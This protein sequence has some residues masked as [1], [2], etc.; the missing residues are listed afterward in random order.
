MNNNK[1]LSNIIDAL[2]HHEDQSS[3][4]VLE[5]VGTNCPDD[6]VRS[7]TAKALISKNTRD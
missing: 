7:L 1:K 2:A 3:I 4:E 6:E 5:R